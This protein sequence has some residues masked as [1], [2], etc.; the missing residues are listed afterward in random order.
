[1]LRVLC[2]TD[3]SKH[4]K[5]ALEYGV[6]ISNL[7]QAELHL[8]T[9]YKV[10]S[11]ASSLIAMEKTIKANRELD[12]KDLLAGI[13]SLITTDILPVTHAT[14]GMAAGVIANYSQH[15]DIDL[16]LWVLKE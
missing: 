8:L 9:A 2:P 13:T 1:M 3:F 11:T 10:P 7:L 15:H 16:M 6:Y 5:K 4:A 12:L 14:K